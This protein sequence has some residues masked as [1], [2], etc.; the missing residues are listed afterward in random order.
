MKKKA[1]II[2]LLLFLIAFTG[3]LFQKN[4]SHLAFS[5]SNSSQG[6]ASITVAPYPQPQITT[7]TTTFLAVGDI[8]LSRFIASQIQQSGNIDFPYLKIADTLTS[9][10]FNFANLESPIAPSGKAIIG[11]SSL[12]FGTPISYAK[13][14]K[15]FNF[16]IVNSANNHAFDR[17]LA[18][19]DTTIATLNNLGIAHEGT[20]D[21]LDQAWTPA[22]VTSHGIKICFI[23]A[24]YSSVND[25]GKVVNNYVARIQ[26][27][28]RLAS[29]IAQARAECDFT[30]V[31]MHAG[32]EYT[33][34]PNT[35][36]TTFAHTAIDDG[37]DM[38][39]GAH[40]HWVQSIENYRGKY[41]FYSLGNF[42]FD[43][44]WSEDTSEGLALKITV[45][46]TTST[47]STIPPSTKLNTIELLPLIITHT[48]PALALP[49]QAS[50]ILQKIG[51]TTNII[52]PQADK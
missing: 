5:Y 7:T 34:T 48:Q 39:I 17:G 8:N 20:G 1:P 30:V 45:S 10:D 35:A 11:G 2:I 49:D 16:Q 29:S 18:G 36:Q 22:V 19:V 24:S 43:Q 6:P 27:T 40:P 28:S 23:G 46:K 37:A 4:L 50:Q 47:D 3:V 25:S 14:L 12:V 15:D 52:S 32:T 38:V 26:D 9:T 31:T 42:I 13:S 21:T 41:I 33:R 51:Q 44:S